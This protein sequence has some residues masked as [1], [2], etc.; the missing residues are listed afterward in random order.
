[1][2]KISCLNNNY[3]HFPA[4]GGGSR[5]SNVSSVRISFYFSITLLLTQE[6]CGYSQYEDG[7][8][9]MSEDF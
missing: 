9:C 8:V 4:G 2:P 1:M 3:I 6:G 5:E 7:F